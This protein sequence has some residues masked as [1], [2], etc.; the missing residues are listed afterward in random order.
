M[1]VYF[2][3]V[4]IVLAEYSVFSGLC[5]ADSSCHNSGP[6]FWLAMLTQLLADSGDKV[7]GQHL[8][9]REDLSMATLLVES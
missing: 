3:L 9:S 4:F 6:S 1:F 7:S 5:I 2:T 8:V